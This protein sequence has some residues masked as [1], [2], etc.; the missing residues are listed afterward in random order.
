MVVTSLSSLETPGDSGRPCFEVTEAFV[1]TSIT[2]HKRVLS[3]P[4]LLQLLLESDEVKGNPFDSWAK[5]QILV[6]KS[7]T[8][9][10]IEWSFHALFHG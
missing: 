8:A 6:Q 10:N 3:N 1:D 5:L 4:S 7:K 2:L 9:K